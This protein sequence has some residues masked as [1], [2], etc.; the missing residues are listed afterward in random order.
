M[1]SLS[2]VS[3]YLLLIYIYT[4]ALLSTQKTPQQTPPQYETKTPVIL[5]AVLG[6]FL[7]LFNAVISNESSH[8]LYH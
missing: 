5:V 8:K 4:L 7:S 3:C 6:M 1:F 2:A